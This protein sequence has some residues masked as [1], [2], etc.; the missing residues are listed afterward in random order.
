MGM[1]T[2]DIDPLQQLLAAVL[3]FLMY[4]VAVI[5]VTVVPAA[6]LKETVAEQQQQ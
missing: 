3:G 6:G 5:G 1:V 2:G 4:K